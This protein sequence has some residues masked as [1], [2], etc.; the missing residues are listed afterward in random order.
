MEARP[1]S[2]LILSN[3]EEEQGSEWYW[4]W[5]VHTTTVKRS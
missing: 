3:G 1:D 4:Q 2:G 5:V